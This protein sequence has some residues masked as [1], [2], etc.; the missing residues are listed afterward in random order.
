MMGVLRASP[1]GCRTPSS[2]WANS[3]AWLVVVVSFTSS[4]VPFFLPVTFPIFKHAFGS[5]LEQMGHM[6]SLFYLSAIAFGLGGGWVVSRLGYRKALVATLLLI[7]TAM[8]MIG[9]ARHVDVVLVGAFCSGL[10]VLSLNVTVS[11]IISEGFSAARQKFFFVQGVS[12][13]A[14]SIAGPA[15]LG[16]WLANTNRLGGS[17]RTA[18]YFAAAVLGAMALWPLFVRSSVLSGMRTGQNGDGSNGLTTLVD[19]LRKPAIHMICL[20]VIL[21]SIAE[22]G[23]I[24]FVGQLFQKRLGVGVAQAA[25]LLSANAAGIFSGRLLLTWIT[26]HWTISELAV[27]ATC[28]VGTTLAF[29]ATIASPGYLLGLA[30]FA[31]SGFC[32]SGTGPSLNSYVGMRFGKQVSTAYSLTSG[33]SYFGSAGGPYLIGFLATRFGLESSMWS[34]PLINL[35][36]AV[37]AL[38]WFWKDKSRNH[39]MLSRI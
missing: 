22:A 35:A 23:M 31:L 1:L 14:G 10:G 20:F 9:G 37:L 12:G 25:L 28:T 3:L 13:A 39:R 11:C 5:T 19:V 6:Q 38:G 36:L 17:W 30:M 4:M 7:V 18:Y 24:S 2:I 32:F 33:T 27:F 29:V 26:S 15:V 21:K 34:L 8:L 16:W